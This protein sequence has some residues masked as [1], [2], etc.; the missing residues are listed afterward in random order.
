MER[1]K[2]IALV[3]GGFDPVH[4][5]H[6]KLL[7]ESYLLCDEI[8]I[9]L[10]NDNWLINKK[11][12]VFQTQE[13]RAGILSRIKAVTGVFVTGHELG[14]KD[15]SVCNELRSIIARAS[16]EYKYFFM[17]GGDRVDTNTPEADVC[18]EL[19]ISVLYGVGG[20]KIQSSSELVRA[21]NEFHNRAQQ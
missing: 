21:V 14:D 1:P 9:I 12:F 17:K 16:S 18:K 2:T 4:L 13:E 11:G 15:T 19:G 5:G 20:G 10:N 8:W 7:Y 6:A 3:S